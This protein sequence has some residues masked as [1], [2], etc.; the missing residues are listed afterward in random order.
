MLSL[1]QTTVALST[2]EDT[3]REAQRLVVALQAEEAP[4]GATL[5]TLSGEL[6]AGKTTFTQC[7][8]KALGVKETVN[9]PTFVIEKIYAISGTPEV[10]SSAH[11][12]TPFTRLVHID[13]YR[14]KSHDDLAVLCFD[15]LLEHPGTLILLEWPEHVPGILESATL[16][17]SLELLA[18]GSRNLSYA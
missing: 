3:E 12:V 11:S 8:A 10:E 9:S 18:D 15:E 1:T 4:E 5:V 17:V 2:L 7:V 6:G 13:A 16:Q 14:L